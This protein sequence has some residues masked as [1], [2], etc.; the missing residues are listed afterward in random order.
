M[1]QGTAQ[2]GDRDCREVAPVR[3][4]QKGRREHGQDN[5]G[6]ENNPHPHTG[7]EVKTKKKPVSK[8]PQKKL[9]LR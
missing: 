5:R 9:P 1:E 4:I 3:R 6:L 8:K 7:K 2:Q